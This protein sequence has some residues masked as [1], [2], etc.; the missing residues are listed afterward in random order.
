MVSSIAIV[1][2]GTMGTGIASNA[3]R[4][5]IEVT[6]LDRSRQALDRSAQQIARQLQKHEEA[7]RLDAAQARA[8]R[9]HIRYTDDVD[10][11]LEADLVIEAVFEDFAV[12][13]KL[14]GHIGAV[15]SET[16]LIATNT[17]ALRVSGLAK[18]VACPGRFLGMH[19]FSP[20]DTSPV[21]ELVQGEQTSSEALARAAAFLQATGRTILHCKDAPGFAINRFFVPFLNAAAQIIDHDGG[22]IRQV[23]EIGRDL[24]GSPVGPFDVMNFIKPV[25]ARNA[26]KN[27]AELGPA[28]TL[29]EGLDDLVERGELWAVEGEADLG[30][31]SA[32]IR[33]LLLKSI[34]APAEE[35]RQAGIADPQE[36][37][38][39]AKLAL[40]W[41]RGPFQMLADNP[42]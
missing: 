25:I 42:D 35:I 27:L 13:T 28:Y 5:G 30:H 40:R 16:T 4:H 1:G 2:A 29:S 19:Y 38:R 12:K 14:L 9:S 10:A 22:T 8:C 37:D 32:A 18:A 21:V 17:S 24:V 31:D 7:G 39:C 41:G 34:A 15:C 3:V 20:A 36:I 26:M 11:P 6:M 23:N 33:Q